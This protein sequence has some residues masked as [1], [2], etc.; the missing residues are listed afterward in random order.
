[1]RPLPEPAKQAL[2]DLLTQ[3]EQEL[4]WP[5]TILL[6]LII[7]L[8]KPNGGERPIALIA[9][10]YRI[11]VRMR[12]PELEVWEAARAG[13]W[14]SAVQGSSALK[15]AL[16]RALADEMAIATDLA[17]ISVLWDLEKFY[18]SIPPHRLLE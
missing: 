13:H 6:N 5:A 3:V 14:D 16:R 2:V 10:L 18:D 11:W 9:I 1:M 4:V 12:K 17:V 8:A 15:A 7:L